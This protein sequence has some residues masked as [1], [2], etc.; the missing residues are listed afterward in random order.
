MPIDL[1]PANRFFDG[2]MSINGDGTG[3]TDM[4]VDGTTPVIFKITPP[5]DTIY[6]LESMSF[7]GS[8]ST[9][10]DSAEE[11]IDLPELTNG[12]LLQVTEQDSSTVLKDFT[13]VPVK[14]NLQF[15]FM[16]ANFANGGNPNQP[17]ILDFNVLYR[18]LYGEPLQLNGANG[19]ELKFTVRDNI[20]ALL[21]QFIE[22]HGRI[23]SI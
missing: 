21:F 9:A 15:Q 8:G 12:C 4:A 23:L 1:I 10:I 7:A 20:S 19:E 17:S 5:A 16:G 2:L 22:F 18:A 14:N 6:I 11:Y 13:P 3:A